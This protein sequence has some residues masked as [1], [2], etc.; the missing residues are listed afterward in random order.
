MML[1][2]VNLKLA[3]AVQSTDIRTHRVTCKLGKI[4]NQSH[5]YASLFS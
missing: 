2:S 3:K 5:D 1:L 4:T